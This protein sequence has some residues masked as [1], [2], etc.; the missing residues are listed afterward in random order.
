MARAD[1]RIGY[2]SL[3][4]N[5]G[6]QAALTAGLDHA[7]G[8]VIV[9]MDSDLQHPPAIVPLLLDKWKEGY[10]VVITVREDD[11]RLSFFKRF[12]SQSFYRLM[13]IFSDTDIRLAASD[14]RLMTRKAVLG[15]KQMP[16]QHR[17][18]RGMV[19]WLGFRSTEIAF[20]PD[21]RRAGKSKYTLGRMLRLAG[22]GLYSF[23]R[24]PLRLASYAGLLFFAL[25]FVHACWLVVQLIAGSTSSITLHYL[26]IVTHLLGGCVLCGL[27]FVG[28]YVG[29]IYEEVKGRPL[30]L[31]KDQSFADLGAGSETKR[32]AA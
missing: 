20:A 21:E 4:R 31:L 29:R 28:E 32:E 10:D 8:D 26:L 6:H 9:S 2:L 22:D 14:F 18:V 15:L 17:F 12:T 5:F 1:A 30:Y 7:R 13:A 27:G 25:G 24:L 3:S 16:E 19:Q 23:S 11:K